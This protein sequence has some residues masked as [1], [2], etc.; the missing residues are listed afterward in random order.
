MQIST[1]NKE[2]QPG[3]QAHDKMAFYGVSLFESSGRNMTIGTLYTPGRAHAALS[4]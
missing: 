1:G 4:S 3:L 2:L